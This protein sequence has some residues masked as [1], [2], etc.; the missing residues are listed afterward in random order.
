[1]RQWTKRLFAV[2]APLLLT[3]CLWGPGK[4]NSDLTL[5]KDGSFSLDYRGE[6][7]LQIPTDAGTPRKWSDD[8]AHCFVR[9]TGSGSL[10]LVPPP[11]APPIITVPKQRPC[12][13][14]EIAA[15]K[16]QFEKTAAET[17]AR[18]KRQA[19]EA[20]KMFGLPGLDDE[21]N[22]AFAAKMMKFAGWRSVVY[23]GN[24]VF[25]VNYHMDGRA[26]QDF[27]FP[28]LPDNDLLLPFIAIRR[29]SDGSVLVTAPALTGGAGPLMGRMAAAG[30]NDTKTSMV[31]RAQGRFTVITDGDIL[32][33]NS[34]DGPA[35]HPIGRQVH[36]DVGPASNKI[37]ETLIRL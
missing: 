17:A 5:R 12:T 28:A 35:P 10:P 37:P 24:G 13:P 3:G 14:A 31:S 20:A 19:E 11:V 16:Q 33:N 36:W 23:R 29:R 18:S 2:A 30:M 26:T 21:S 22:R 6:I 8:Q 1:M 25:D 15:Q 27:I 4:F 7:V 34:E 9:Q 32:T